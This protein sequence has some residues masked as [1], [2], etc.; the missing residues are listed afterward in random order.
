MPAKLTTTINNIQTVPNLIN[1]TIIHEFYQY[2]TS[3]DSSLHHKNNNLKVIIAFANFLG[4]DVTFHEVK[5]KEQFLAFL[6]TKVKDSDSD[7]EKRWITTWN[8]YLN[9]IRFFFRWL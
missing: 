3:T 6:N 1:S 4:S 8:H 2:M 5:K 7:P 9:R